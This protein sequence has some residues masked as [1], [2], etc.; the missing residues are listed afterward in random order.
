[1]GLS[2][3]IVKIIFQYFVNTKFKEHQQDTGTFIAWA[4]ADKNTGNH[5]VGGV[6]GTA[7]TGSNRGIR[8]N[9]GNWDIIGRNADWTGITSITTNQWNL[10]AFTWDGT[11]AKFYLNGQEYSN[12]VSGLV[13]PTGTVLSAGGPPWSLNSQNWDGKID[14]V[15]VY[16]YART[17]AQIA[18]DS[19][20]AW[21]SFSRAARF[22]M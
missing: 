21:A 22:A 9:N 4:W 13:I 10:V 6:G 5:F 18:W 2:I 7:T 14:Q 19:W 8:Q 11:S 17:P 15:V 1:M 3:F 12:T 20:A 16:N